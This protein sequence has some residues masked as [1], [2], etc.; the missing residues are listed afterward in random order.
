M[1]PILGTTASQ[2]IGRLTSYESIATTTVGAG[3]A[4][5][6]TFSS[7]PAGYQHLQIRYN[8]RTASTSNANI[9]LN[10]NGDTTSTAVWHVLYGQGN[11]SAA[12][13]SF[14]SAYI[15]A[16]QTAASNVAAGIFGVGV[17]DIL[18]YK[19]TSK[20]KTVR[21]MSGSD[22]NGAG[23]IYF[24]SGQWINTNAITSLVLTTGDAAN[25]SQYSQFALY[26]IKG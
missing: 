15:I 21:S 17:I 20:N 16:G 4:S 14:T 19:N 1:T 25:F 5:S 10:V 23:I 12:V 7:I 11:G 13:Y 8:A 6:I 22:S 3:G 2:L 18:D 9:N 24:S 26:G